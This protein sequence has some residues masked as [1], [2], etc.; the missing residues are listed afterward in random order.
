MNHELELEFQLEWAMKDY[1]R[2][3]NL[4]SGKLNPVDRKF[5]KVGQ[6]NL[7]RYINECLQEKATQLQDN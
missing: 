4:L 1:M 5:F 7:E 2:Y 3:S 6:R